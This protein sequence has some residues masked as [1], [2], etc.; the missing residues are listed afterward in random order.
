MI[1]LPTV[2]VFYKARFVLVRMHVHVLPW[3]QNKPYHE[4]V[5]PKGCI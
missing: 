1:L 2:L 3:F 4:A 5:A